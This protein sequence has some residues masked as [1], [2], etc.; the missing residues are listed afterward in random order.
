MV[1]VLLLFSLP[2]AANQDARGSLSSQPVFHLPL[3]VHVGNSDRAPEDWL[4]ILEEI[5]DIWHSQAGICFAIEIVTDDEERANG[6]DLWFESTIK[7]WNGYFTDRHDMHVRDNPE[8]RPAKH[9]ARSSA[10]RTA[11]HEPF[12]RSNRS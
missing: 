7:N 4:P 11:A 6:L 3:R 9:P 12:I 2:A 10:A 5:N 8:L 1:S